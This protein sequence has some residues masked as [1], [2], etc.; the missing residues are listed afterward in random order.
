M[1]WAIGNAGRSGECVVFFVFS[2]RRC[3]ARWCEDD[4]ARCLSQLEWG[5]FTS[6]RSDGC[7][8]QLIFSFVTGGNGRLRGIILRETQEDQRKVVGD[9][10]GRVSR[11]FKRKHSVT[12][13]FL[14]LTTK[15]NFIVYVEVT[16]NFYT[17]CC[18]K[19]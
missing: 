6:S 14:S 3:Q 19:N 10:R 2:D 17:V 15:I 1:D 16:S 12:S 18:F 9:S 4:T 11:V 8:P 5:T 13:H 7:V